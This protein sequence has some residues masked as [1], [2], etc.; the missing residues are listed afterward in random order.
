MTR[1]DIRKLIGGYATGSLSKAERRTLFETALD[2]QELFDEL[3]REQALKE[4]LEEPGAKQRLIAALTPRVERA[5]WSKPWIWIGAAAVVAIVFT[6]GS[7]AV[8]HPAAPAEL[9][10]VR[11][12]AA[13]EPRT[14]ESA[15]LQFLL[16]QLREPRRVR[17]ALP[18]FGRP[19]PVPGE[20]PPVAP[21][22][23]EPA[24]E[25]GAK[26]DQAD[27]TPKAAAIPQAAPAPANPA[28]REAAPVVAPRA[29]PAIRAQ[30]GAAQGGAGGGG[31]LGGFGQFSARAV[32]GGARFAF[33]YSVSPEGVLPRNAIRPWFSRGR[34][35]NTAAVADRF[36]SPS[37]KCRL[38]LSLNFR[39]RP[40][41]RWSRFF[42]PREKHP[43][44]L[45]SDPWGRG[46]IP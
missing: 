23:I 6:V 14:T 36:C 4:L 20:P 32:S 46:Q 30:N 8:H 41:Q 12:P 19:A 34:L 31:A 29:A 16:P 24:P 27:A 17:N 13:V 2:D 21:L 1:E 3:A 37:G 33:D 18:K 40:V 43:L 22:P 15:R 35:V 45:P 26:T 9:A 44:R 39:Y 42:S 7:I 25:A 10:Q 28:A 11:V 5:W 38:V